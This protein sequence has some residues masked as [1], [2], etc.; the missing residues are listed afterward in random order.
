LSRFA[1]VDEVVE[2]FKMNDVDLNWG[3]FVVADAKGRSVVIEWTNGRL[4][5]LQ[6]GQRPG[7][8][9]LS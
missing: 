6:N 5:V 1:A 3:M 9:R 8:S 2:F 7:I 4:Q